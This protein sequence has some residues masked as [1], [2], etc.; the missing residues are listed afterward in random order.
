[1]KGYEEEHDLVMV[2]GPHQPHDG[3]EE[4]EDADGDDS[5]DEV[6]AGDDAEAFA[7]GGHPDQQQAH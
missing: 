7:P 3:D 5:A 4:E 6:D 2:D 1:M